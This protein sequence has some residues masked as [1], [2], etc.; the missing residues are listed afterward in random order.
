MKPSVEPPVPVNGKT[1]KFLEWCCV[2]ELSFFILEVAT[3]WQ[4]T[5]FKNSDSS[6][7]TDSAITHFLS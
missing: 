4:G 1:G 2:M 5:G 7:C 6:G 3:Y